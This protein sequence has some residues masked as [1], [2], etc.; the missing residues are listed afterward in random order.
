MKRLL[1]VLLLALVPVCAFGQ[2]TNADKTFGGGS[3]GGAGTVT[4]VS[5]GNGLSGGPITSTGTIDLRLSTTG[6]LSKTQGGGSNELGVDALG[7]TAAMLFGAIPDSKLSTIS[8]S[9]K[10]ADSALSANVSLLGNTTSGTGSVLRSGSPT[11]SAPIIADFS[12]STHNHSNAAGGGQIDT[13]AF[14]SGSKTGN[15]TKFATSTGTLTSGRCAEWDASGNLVQSAAGCAA[16]A[17]TSV[18]LSLPSVFTISGS[19]VT[20]SGTLGATFATGQIASRVLATDTSSS[21]L[22]LRQIDATYIAAAAKSG[23]GTKLV[24]LGAAS[25]SGKCAEFD[26]S[27]NVTVSVSNVPCGSASAAGSSGNVQVN[28]GGAFGAWGN[29]SVSGNNLTMDGRL[30]WSMS[31]G[32]VLPLAINQPGSPSQPAAVFQQGGTTYFS[33]TERRTTN[34]QSIADPGT[35][36]DGD[37]WKSSTQK[38][39]AYADFSRNFYLPVVLGVSASTVSL[40]NNTEISLIGSSLT[41]SKTIPANY[42]VIG[43]EICVEGH[44]YMTTSA[45]PPNFTGKYVLGSTIAMQTGANTPPASLSNRAVIVNACYTVRTTGAGGTAIGQGTFSFRDNSGVLQVWDMVVTSPVTIDTTT[46]QTLDFLGAW[47]STV[48]GNSVTMTNWKLMAAN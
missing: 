8:T 23:N 43:K 39:I 27:G 26:A 11:I 20:A 44:G 33:V 21:A 15:G 5:T 18:G 40:T 30:I 34:Y 16:A 45:S 28:N 9:G 32:A 29:T 1:A 3:G 41:G 24:T 12:G 36:S 13:S 35:P 38:A 6:G 14:P 46:A 7:I 42:Q 48:G 47:S 4:S 22:D 25:T 31:S 37:F 19:P 17:V 10:V 2:K